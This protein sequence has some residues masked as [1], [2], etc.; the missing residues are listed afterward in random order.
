MKKIRLAVI[1]AGLIAVLSGVTATAQ[2]GGVTNCGDF[3][4]KDTLSKLDVK[5]CT[6]QS[7]DMAKCGN[8]WCS[9]QEIKDTIQNIL[10]DYCL[11]NTE[12]ATSCN[13]GEDCGSDCGVNE[14]CTSDCETEDFCTTDQETENTCTSDC[15]TE[16]ICTTDCGTENTCTFDCDTENICTSD[17]ETEES[18]NSDC[19]GEGADTCTDCTDSSDSDTE[20]V[21]VKTGTW[22][23]L[24]SFLK[25]FYNRADTDITVPDIETDVSEDNQVQDGYDVNEYE[26]RVCDLVN[27]IR[28]QYGLSPLT[29][30]DELSNVARIKS[31]DMRDKGYFSHNS[32]TYGSPFDMMKQ[33]GISYRTAGENIAM[34]QRTPEEVVNAWMN[35]EGHRA[36]ILNS[37]F[38]Q[39]G[40]GYVSDGN[41]W[42]QMFIG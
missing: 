23:D 35:S 31:Q 6:V 27:D 12:C 28:T 40:V 37:T 25:Q 16:N 21:I 8:D 30:N 7:I 20:S 9:S 22:E 29:V 14:N 39:I 38:T 15:D 42:T 5:T 32:P 13:S 4:C 19:A 36:N 24:E 3:L 33:F 1:A 41:Y 17:C 10:N 34:G 26:Q 11:N 2:C 18:C